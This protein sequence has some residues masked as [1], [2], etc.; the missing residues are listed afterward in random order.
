MSTINKVPAGAGAEW[1]LGA[2]ALIRKAPVALGVL[3]LI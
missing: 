3:G 1:L 2:F